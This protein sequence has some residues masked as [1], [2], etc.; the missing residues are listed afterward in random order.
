MK[1]FVLE[2]VSE[3]SASNDGELMQ[4]VP[5]TNRCLDQ[6][7]LKL[8]QVRLVLCIRTIVADHD[9]HETVQS[10]NLCFRCTAGALLKI[11]HQNHI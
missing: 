2:R 6:V 3:T 4:K 7:Y 8:D 10:A 11:A 9:T 1:A 5:I